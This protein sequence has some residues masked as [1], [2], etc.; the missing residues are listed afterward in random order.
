MSAQKDKKGCV[1][2]A[3]ELV[4]A[5]TNFWAHVA[6]PDAGVTTPFARNEQ[7]VR[8]FHLDAPHCDN[9]VLFVVVFLRVGFVRLFLTDKLGAQ[10]KYKNIFFF[11]F[12]FFLFL[13]S[14]RVADKHRPIKACETNPTCLSQITFVN[15]KIQI[16]SLSVSH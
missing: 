15:Q 14:F 2:T 1:P 13:F 9:C 4:H 11:F 5:D 7:I 10:K 8:L 3:R 6:P 12:F 16:F